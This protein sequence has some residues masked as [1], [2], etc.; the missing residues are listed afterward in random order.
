MS[1]Q[2][3]SKHILLGNIFLGVLVFGVGTFVASESISG[4]I[5]SPGIVIVD[6]SLKKIQS[7][8]GGIVASINVKDGSHVKAGEPLLILDDTIAKSNL[9]I[10]SNCLL[11]T[12]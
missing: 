7:I 8:S 5:V 3:I 6:S 2:S 9:A 10:I 1:F 12:S 11:Y 4:A